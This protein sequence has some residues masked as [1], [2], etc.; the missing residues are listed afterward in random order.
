VDERLEA[1]DD[2]VDC[3]EEDDTDDVETEELDDCEVE[4]D[5]VVVVVPG[6]VAR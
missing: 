6:R 3:I 4:V 1:I 5:E 2:E